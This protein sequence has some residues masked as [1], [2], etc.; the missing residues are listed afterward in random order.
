MRY[1]FEAQRIALS[2]IVFAKIMETFG[3]MTDGC[4]VTKKSNANRELNIS[5]MEPSFFD[6]RCSAHSSLQNHDQQGT[7][8]LR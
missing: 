5:F 6:R 3:T 7:Q 1:K 2:H 8:T 4:V